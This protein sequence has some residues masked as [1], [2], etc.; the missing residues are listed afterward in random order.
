MECSRLTQVE[1]DRGKQP[2]PCSLTNITS[3]LAY[4][5]GYNEEGVGTTSSGEQ[6][7]QNPIY[8]KGYYRLT[9]NLTIC[10][11]K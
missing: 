1:H 8:N 6:L 2:I 5:V 10:L 4:L 9:S 7:I 3:F 11:V